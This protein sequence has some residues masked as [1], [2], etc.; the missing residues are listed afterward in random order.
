MQMD[1]RVKLVKLQEKKASKKILNRV[2]ISLKKIIPSQ[3][4]LTE[5]NNANYGA[6]RYILRLH[7]ISRKVNKRRERM[8]RYRNGKENYREKLNN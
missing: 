5:I 3:A 7:R 2:N 6:A 1:D 4:T 8:T